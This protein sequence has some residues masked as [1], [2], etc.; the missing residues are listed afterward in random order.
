MCFLNRKIETE[1]NNLLDLTYLVINSLEGREEADSR[2]TDIQQLSFK[3]FFHAASLQYLYKGTEFKSNLGN[4]RNFFDFPSY[5]IIFRSL[6]ETFIVLT[7]VFFEPKNDDE[8]S[9]FYYVWK[10]S[11]LIPIMKNMKCTP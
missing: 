11:G 10:L 5:A 6:L 9:F 4:D 3:F 2:R 8:F 1:Y 7:I